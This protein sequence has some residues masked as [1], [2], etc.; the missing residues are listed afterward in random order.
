MPA[1]TTRRP[2]RTA[3]LAPLAALL[4]APALAPAATPSLTFQP[5]A[6]LPGVP[7]PPPSA[8]GHSITS[9]PAPERAEP[10]WTVEI[11]PSVWFVAPSGKLALP[12]NSGTGPAGFTTAG[13]EVKVNDINLDSNRLSPSGEL[14]L[15]SGRFRLTFQGAD[16]ELTRDRTFPDR[17][18]RLGAV[19]FTRA[20]ALKIDFSF[21]TYEV[22]AGYRVWDRDFKAAGSSTGYAVDAV[23]GLYALAGVRMYDVDIDVQRLTGTFARAEASHFFAEPVVGARLE[24]DFVEAFALELQL[25]AGYLPGGDHE[26]SSIDV[27]LAFSWRPS[28]NFG[29]RLGWRQVAFDL[30]DG[31]GA[32]KF[33]YDGRLAGLFIGAVIRF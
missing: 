3:A 29:V 11:L 9:S 14:H 23:V 28:R 4:A 7:P 22:T 13:D 24:A 5:D 6:A 16:F 27:A 32:S 1:P 30:A 2:A 21:G 33:E 8:P 17:A 15:S 19:A 20:D 10:W 31:S 12:V 18:G 25:D 26:S